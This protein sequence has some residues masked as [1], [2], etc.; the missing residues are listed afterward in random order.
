MNYIKPAL[1]GEV[2]KRFLNTAIM[3]TKDVIDAYLQKNGE[4][5]LTSNKEA[6]TEL[7]VEIMKEVYSLTIKDINK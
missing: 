5:I 7:A 2:E 4:H 1:L 3:K 6:T